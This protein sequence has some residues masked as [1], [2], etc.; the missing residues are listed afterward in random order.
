M[1]CNRCG[2][3][4]LDVELHERWHD[5]LE[6]AAVDWAR[7][8]TAAAERVEVQVEQWIEQQTEINDGVLR[9]CRTLAAAV[10]RLSERSA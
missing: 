10:D 2:L 7:K 8:A 1:I 4:P 9:L 5:E 6:G 3:S